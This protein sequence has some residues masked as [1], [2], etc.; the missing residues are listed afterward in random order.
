MTVDAGTGDDFITHYQGETHQTYLWAKGDGNDTIDVYT[1]GGSSDVLDLT[2]VSSSDVVLSRVGM[3]IR[4]GIIS[5]GEIIDIAHNWY[6]ATTNR[7]VNTL[8]FADGSSLDRAQLDSMAWVRGTVGDDALS[9]QGLSNAT[10]DLGAGNDSYF[11]RY[12]GGNTFVYDSGDGSDTYDTWA[13]WANTNALKL[14]DLLQTDVTLGR[15]G[16]DLL[17]TVNGTGDTITD[18]WQF[19]ST[20]NGMS[21]LQFADGSSLDQSQITAA[22]W[23]R[24]GTGDVTVTAKDGDATLVSGP[25]TDILVGAAGNDRFIYAAGSGN[26]TIQDHADGSAPARSNTLQLAGIN[27]DGVALAQNGSD[28]VVS[29]AATGKAITVGGQ[30]NSVDHD[31]R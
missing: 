10:F 11:D 20:N 3:D 2:D 8:E 30:F 5:T 16:S 28:L 19:A 1:P 22:A 25:G 15:S 9:Y 27:P 12:V 14:A 13:P 23:Y 31:D 18:K 4:V 7:G 17:I 26:L 29:I 21:A 24:A 6:D